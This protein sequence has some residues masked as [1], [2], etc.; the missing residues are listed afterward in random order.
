[1]FHG[2]IVRKLIF[3]ISLLT[4]R[5]ILSIFAILTLKLKDMR[6]FTT[7]LFLLLTLIEAN[8]Q[9]LVEPTEQETQDITSAILGWGMMSSA[10]STEQTQLQT[11]YRLSENP[12]GYAAEDVNALVDRLCGKKV[13]QTGRVNA[14]D[15]A[16]RIVNGVKIQTKY[17]KSA[18]STIKTSFDK[19]TG[20]YRYG[21]QLLEVPKDQYEEAVRL[22]KEKI[23]EGKVPGVT[24]PEDAKKLVKKGFVTYAQA[25][26]IAKAGTVESVGFDLATGAVT[27][28]CTAGLS[29]AILFT[30]Y[31]INGM[32]ADQAA[33]LAA[34]ESGCTAGIV[35]LAHV[36]S[37][38]FFRTKA[39]DNIIKR[40]DKI[41]DDLVKKLA[42]TE[43]GRKAIEAVASFV[44]KSHLTGKKA[45]DV[46]RR[47]IS[48]N[49]VTGTLVTGSAV[50]IEGYKVCAGKET[51]ADGGTNVA[52]GV[53]GTAL[54]CAEPGEAQHSEQLYVQEWEQFLALCA[55]SEPVISEV[56]EPR[57]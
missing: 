3:L 31:C 12:H 18:S 41:A 20:L 14:S 24:N 45:M 16:D 15:G 19:H 4:R 55:E 56:G 46:C 7:I 27:S 28:A 37:Q 49:I 6:N 1:M 39:A 44:S 48:S 10:G 53:A 50:G 43:K 23:K 2:K 42:L 47:L 40:I 13:T 11:F 32:D 34:K 30:N 29:F 54:G 38:Q 57:N 35:L 26:K 22:M 51:L 25:A 36:G 9:T 52:S 17:C 8:A 33:L 21:N 5:K